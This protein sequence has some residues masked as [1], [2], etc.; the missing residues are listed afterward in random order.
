MSVSFVPFTASEGIIRFPQDLVGGGRVYK[1]PSIP[2]P[3][4]LNNNRS[5]VVISSIR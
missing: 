1:D 4:T 5:L 2:P 3:P